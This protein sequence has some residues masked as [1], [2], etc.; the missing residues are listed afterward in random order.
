MRIR[1]RIRGISRKRYK[2]KKKYKLKMKRGRGFWS[3]VQKG[4]DNALGYSGY[5]GFY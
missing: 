2:L 1:R 5:S 4:L 3:N